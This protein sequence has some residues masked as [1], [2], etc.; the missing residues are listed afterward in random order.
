MNIDTMNYLKN[1]NTKN[2]T[3]YIIRHGESVGNL[4]RICLGHTDLDLTDL[5][6]E[7]AKKTA[8]ALSDLDFSAIY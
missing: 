4:N 2:T 6:V 5:G 1:K 8:D 7:Q 3:I